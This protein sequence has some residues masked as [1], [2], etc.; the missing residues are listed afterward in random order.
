MQVITLD[1]LPKGIFCTFARWNYARQTPNAAHTH[2]FHELFWIESGEGIEHI[3]GGSRPLRSGM[4]VLTRAE[5]RHAFSAAREGTSVDFV[6]FAFPVFVWSRLKRRFPRLRGHYF[7]RRPIDQRVHWLNPAELAR[8]RVLSHELQAGNQDEFNTETF[9]AGVISLLSGCERQKPASVMPA[10]LAGACK[11]IREPVRFAGGTRAFAT[12]AGRS[13]EHLA[14]SLK[15]HLGRTPTEVV[16]EARL[17]HA[18]LLLCTTGR[19]ILDIAAECG[20]ENAGHFYALFRARFQMTPRRYRLN[21]AYPPHVF[22]GP[23]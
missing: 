5:D 10:W 11:G 2:T 16:N 17:D 8:L 6:N 20:F 3:N 12:L 4:M 23:V 13:P 9:L 18:A 15:R 14:R 7:D 1:E 22:K 19:G 21:N